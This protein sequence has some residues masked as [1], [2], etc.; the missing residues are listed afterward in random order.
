MALITISSASA[1]TMMPT[2]IYYGFS[3]VANDLATDW[4]RSASI[5]SIFDITFSLAELSAVCVGLG[6]VKHVVHCGITI[7]WGYTIGRSMTAIG[8]RSIELACKRTK[9]GLYMEIYLLL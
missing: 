8:V 5:G 3:R 1:P 7:L 9:Q 4:L 2:S 6:C